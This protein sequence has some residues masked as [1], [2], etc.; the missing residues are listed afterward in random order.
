MAI[1]KRPLNM[2][3]LV[4]HVNELLLPDAN[5][6][7]LRISTIFDPR[8]P[9]KILG[10]SVRLRQILLNL[11]GNAIKFTPSGAVS[12]SV[13]S[14]G[15]ATGD[16]RLRIEVQDT[17]IGIPEEAIKTLFDEFTQADSSTTRQFG[18]TGLGLA[19]CQ[20]LTELM[21]GTIG[22]ESEP[23]KGSLF[24][25]EIDA[26]AAAD[27]LAS[28]VADLSDVSCVLVSDAD[29]LRLPLKAQLDAWS[30]K[31]DVFENISEGLNLIRP[32]LTGAKNGI[33]LLAG[34][35]AI[36]DANSLLSHIHAR[37]ALD[38]LLTIVTANSAKRPKDI[39]ASPLQNF[40]LTPVSHDQLR[41]K[42][43][44]MMGVEKQS[45]DSGLSKVRSIRKQPVQRPLKILV[46]ED[47][48]VNQLLIIR[49]LAKVGHEVIIAENGN[50][51]VKMATSNDVDLILMD[52][53]MPD[54]NGIEA[55]RQIR[56]LGGKFSDLP[57][58]ML[59]A[60]SEVEEKSIYAGLGILEVLLKPINVEQLSTLI[61][62]LG[63]IALL[64]DETELEHTKKS[65]TAVLV[66]LVEEIGKA[67]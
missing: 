8:L 25:I 6:K 54:L 62:N 49:L 2:V 4:D 17:G 14:L 65:D 59:T 61:Q 55:A 33:V 20:R 39:A 9:R 42:I 35:N 19:I 50:M 36:E 3:E 23:G 44:D 5:D 66:D 58:A 11:V 1:E 64:N 15:E 47:N 63:G 67:S 46:A 18:G 53:K 57:I 13:F 37:A 26:P 48:Q 30:T 56:K 12:V 10:D 7:E 51:A 34:T 21:N 31:V 52:L 60:S 22:V 43:C 41:S 38:R 28:E 29:Y 16:H 27:S 45:K 24:W 40:L 32:I